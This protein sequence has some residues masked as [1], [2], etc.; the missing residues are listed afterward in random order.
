IGWRADENRCFTMKNGLQPLLRR[1]PSAGN[2]H[3]AHSLSRFECGPKSDERPKRK[4]DI[5]PIALPHAGAFENL[6]QASQPPIPT[7]RRVEPKYRPACST[8]GLVDSRVVLHGKSQ[9]CTERRVVRLIFNKLLFCREWY[10]LKA[11]RLFQPIGIKTVSV[12]ENRA[13]F[14]ET[15]CGCHSAL[16][17]IKQA[18]EKAGLTRGPHTSGHTRLRCRPSARLLSFFLIGSRCLLGFTRSKRLRLANHA[19]RGGSNNSSQ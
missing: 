19:I 4:R 8:G 10:V 13:H 14:V 15:R 16:F 3:E 12:G 6:Y 11:N 9:I 18:V 1:L 17:Y 2:T 7:F 5:H